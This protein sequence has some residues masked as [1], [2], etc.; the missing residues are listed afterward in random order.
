MSFRHCVPQS[1]SVRWVF[2]GVTILFISSHASGHAMQHSPFPSEQSAK[3]DRKFWLDI[4]KN[5]YAVP[6]GEP[7]FPLLRELSAY[8]ASPDPQLRDDLAYSILYVWI[9]ARP[10]LTDPELLSLL[11]DWQSNLRLGIGES[12]TDTVLRRSFSALCLAAIA[13]R[14]LR[15]P[16]L[17][18]LRYR[19]LLDSAL[20][21]LHDERDLRGFDPVKGWIHS[22][23]HTA[24]LLAS[25]AA[26]PLLKVED[27]PRVLHAVAE[28][29]S[30]AHQIFSYGEQDRLAFTIASIVARKDFDATAFR[31]WLSALDETDRQVWKSSPPD[32]NRLKT[33]E[34]NSYLLQALAARLNVQPQ[35]LAIETAL[36][37]VT[38][39]L[40]KR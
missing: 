21:Y 7:V 32:A 20:N 40:R 22:T 23:A 4:S 9:V 5:N 31:T 30:S 38:Q 1:C 27:Q 13:E 33:F 15:S 2:A 34:N 37:Q 12:N 35:P 36:G 18:E 26:N 24:D 39:I 19:A 16:F 10:R 14:D 6:E 8:L 11:D 3:H 28:R 29:L 25:L 17:G